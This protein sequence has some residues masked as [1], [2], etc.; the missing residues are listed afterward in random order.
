MR[1]ISLRYPKIFLIDEGAFLKANV[2]I[3]KALL[4]GKENNENSNGCCF[5]NNLQGYAM[6]KLTLPLLISG[7]LLAQLKPSVQ[8]PILPPGA[9]LLPTQLRP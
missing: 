9:E 3:P 5:K 6:K 7:A 2:I 4:T 8:S 1:N